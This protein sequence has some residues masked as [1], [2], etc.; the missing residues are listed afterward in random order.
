MT[1]KFDYTRS[2]GT[3]VTKNLLKG[4]PSVCFKSMQEVVGATWSYTCVFAP[5]CPCSQDTKQIRKEKQLKGMKQ[6]VCPFV[7]KVKIL[8]L[9]KFIPSSLDNMIHD[10]NMS[11]DITGKSL[12][13]T[14]PRTFL[15][16]TLE[17]LPYETFKIMTKSKYFFPYEAVNT[18][19]WDHL[20]SITSF[21]PEDFKSTLRHSEGLTDAEFQE[22]Q[23]LSQSLGV[24]SL[25]DLIRQYNI[26]DVLLG[27]D[28]T[29]FYFDHLH[30]VCGIFP[31]HVYTIASLS[32]RSF[33]LAS[34]DPEHP[35]RKLFLPFL[36]EDVY[37]SFSKALQ[38]SFCV[39]FSLFYN[40]N[41]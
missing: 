28:T 13:Q 3:V 27:S 36:S 6:G 14:F 4:P 34:S 32:I 24:T 29:T 20:S 17:H 33:L 11:R 9:I 38:V 25:A 16:T 21:K 26:S 8:D 7:R 39:S 41:V 30:K 22:F 31:S 1:A 23:I 10:M 19:D 2:D 40:V 5:D 35:H 12:E 15:H 37:N 18:R